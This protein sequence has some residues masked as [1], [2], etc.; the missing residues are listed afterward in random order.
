MDRAAGWHLPAKR[1]WDENM[2]RIRE[3]LQVTA[4]LVIEV[5]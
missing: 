3:L 1:C 5:K 2:K 4:R